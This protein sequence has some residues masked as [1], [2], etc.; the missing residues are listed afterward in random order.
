[1]GTFGLV[2]ECSTTELTPLLVPSTISVYINLTGQ[3]PALSP[4]I[5]PLGLCIKPG[6]FCVALY[7]GFPHKSKSFFNLKNKS[8]YNSLFT[9]LFLLITDCVISESVAIDMIQFMGKVGYFY[10]EK[11]HL[12]LYIREIQNLLD[13][14]GLGP[15]C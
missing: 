5:N 7:S 4:W 15:I 8:I 6:S 13:Y 14:G 9:V 2:D 12:H 3:L 11:I 1:M 10:E